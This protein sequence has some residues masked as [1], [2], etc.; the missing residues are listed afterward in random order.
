M[1]HYKISFEDLRK[2]VP[3]E[4]PLEDHNGKY[5]V[6]FFAFNMMVRP[7]WLP[8]LPVISRFTELNFRTYLTIDGK[9]GVYFFTLEAGKKLSAWIS[10][11]V[12]GLNYIYS[13]MSA[14]DHSIHSK[15]RE[16]D[17]AIDAR[18]DPGEYLDDKSGLDKWLTE[19][20]CLYDVLNGRIVRYDIH[21]VEWPL[22]KLKIIELEMHYRLG[23]FIAGNEPVRMHYSEGVEVVG[24][25]RSEE[26]EK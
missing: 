10:R 3:A 9:P 8:P 20:Y 13:E 6:S 14:I 15:N 21:H 22:R 26:V 5:Y 4:L 11:T 1:L 24:R 25:G 16:R 19:R 23:N 12:T 7:R 2:V 17:Y 18:F